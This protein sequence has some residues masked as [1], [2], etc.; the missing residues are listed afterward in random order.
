MRLTARKFLRSLLPI[1]RSGGALVR[2]ERGAMAVEFGLLSIPF[3]VIIGAIL[4]T[5]IVF[6]AGQVLDSAVHD[7][8]RKV[9]TG[10]AQGANFTIAEFRA[11]ICGRLYSLFDCSG[12]KIRVTPLVGFSGTSAAIVDP[13]T[14]DCT[15]DYTAVPPEDCWEI[16]ETFQPGAGD[17]I[18][19]V[20]VYYK[21]P[22]IIDFGGFNLQNQQDGTRLLAAVRVF[23]NEP[24]G[25]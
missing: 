23:A 11:D 16:V 7:A 18:E 3:F 17:S 1:R 2:D 25:S 9:R 15:P 21:W 14:P 12:L 22:T 24:F 19:L 20:Q 13:V 4:E 8:S 6:L 5:S 10:E